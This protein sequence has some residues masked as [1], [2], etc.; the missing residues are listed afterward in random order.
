MRPHCT[1][2]QSQ[3][4]SSPAVHRY[5]PLLAELFL[6]LVDLTDEVDEALAR[7]GDPLLRPVSELELSDGPALSVPGV[8][9]LGMIVL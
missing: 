6:G 9:H 1:P 3:L 8:R 7:L 4:T 5:W 2:S